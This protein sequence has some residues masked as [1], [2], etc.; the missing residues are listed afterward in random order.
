MGVKALCSGIRDIDGTY[1]TTER[2]DEMI[3]VVY[4]NQ[5]DTRSL[6]IKLK[7]GKGER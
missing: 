1:R 6:R 4:I 2:G 5:K 7:L 3:F